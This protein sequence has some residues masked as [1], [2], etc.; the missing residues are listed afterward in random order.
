MSAKKDVLWFAIY[1]IV[2]DLTYV[3]I[4][5]DLYAYYGF[6]FEPDALKTVISWVLFVVVAFCISSKRTNCRTLFLYTVMCLSL[7][8]V[9]VY[10]QYNPEAK[11]W[12]LVAQAAMLV[13]MDIIMN[14][15]NWFANFTVKKASYSSKFLRGS[16]FIILAVYFAFVFLKN[17]MPSFDMLSFENIGEIRENSDA[18]L[19][20]GLVQN[21]ICKIVIPVLMMIFFLKRKW[22]PFVFVLIIQLYTYTVTG[23]KTFLFIPVVIIGLSIFYKLDINRLMLRALPIVCICCSLL[24]LWFDEIYPYALINERVLFLPA[25]IKFAYFD[26]FSA[27]EFAYFSQTTFGMLFGSESAYTQPIPNI[28]GDVYFGKPD[29][30]TNTGFMADAYSNMGIFGMLLISVAL[31]FILSWVDMT[32][33]GNDVKLNRGILGMFLLFF[34]SLNDGSAITVFFS[35]GMVLAVL[36]TSFIAFRDKEKLKPLD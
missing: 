11:T 15:V 24:Y 1:K 12:M 8:P 4:H 25:K 16:V 26:Y 14:R 6:G 21:V 2:L 13:I 3:F 18:S 22:I 32:L 20:L 36:M 31:A 30:W 23:F 9:F 7:T 33:K 28:I 10:Y 17:G 34:I 35:G 5:K 27:N 19:L 29:M